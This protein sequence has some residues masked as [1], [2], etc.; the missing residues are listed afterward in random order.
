[1]VKNLIS[2]VKWKVTHWGKYTTYVTNKVYLLVVERLWKRKGKLEHSEGESTLDTKKYF[3]K[4]CSFNMLITVQPNSWETQREKNQDASSHHLHSLWRNRETCTF[5]L[6]VMWHGTIPNQGICYDVMKLPEYL[7][8]ESAVSFLRIYPKVTMWKEKRH[9][10][11]V[12]PARTIH[13]ILR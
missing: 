8:L 13:K 6:V 4:K 7:P 9:K 1:M 10:H 2:K 11:K 3:P 12:I 5:L